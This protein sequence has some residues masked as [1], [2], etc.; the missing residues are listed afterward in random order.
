VVSREGKRGG[1]KVCDKLRGLY[2]VVGEKGG[3]IA[4]DA[5]HGRGVSG[6]LSQKKR[7]DSS[8]I[9]KF[10]TL[11]GK[12]RYRGGV[13]PAPSRMQKRRDAIINVR[14]KRE[15]CVQKTALGG[16]EDRRKKKKLTSSFSKVEQVFTERNRKRRKGADR[17]VTEGE[18]SIE[19]EKMFHVPS[20][21]CGLNAGKG[22]GI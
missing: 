14:K 10:R 1:E 11:G 3:W 4:M 20:H 5:P 22:R 21:P 7:G 8:R 13:I 16:P 18:A 17:C 15:Y 2:M 19:K 6:S 9:R 12:I